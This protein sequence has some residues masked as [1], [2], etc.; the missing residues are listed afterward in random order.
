MHNQRKPFFLGNHCSLP[1]NASVCVYSLFFS[2]H[3]PSDLCSF[4]IPLAPLSCHS[5]TTEWDK[6]P[7]QPHLPPASRSALRVPK[8][9]AH[10]A[11]GTGGGGGGGVPGWM[12][13][14]QQQVRA[15]K[16]QTEF[17]K[18]RLLSLL[19]LPFFFLFFLFKGYHPRSPAQQHE[20]KLP[21]TAASRSTD[22]RRCHQHAAQP[23]AQLALPSQKPR[24][25]AAVP[26][27]A[28]L[29]STLPRVLTQRCI[30]AAA[31]ALRSSSAMPWCWPQANVCK[32]SDSSV[33]ELC[34]QVLPSTSVE[35]KSNMHKLMIC[36]RDGQN[37]RNFVILLKLLKHKGKAIFNSVQ[38]DSANYNDKSIFCIYP[39]NLSPILLSENYTASPS[40]G[41]S[42]RCAPER[43]TPL[44]TCE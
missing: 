2:H 42:T 35:T 36:Y 25:G 10:H 29:C 38:K 6:E 39:L 11:Q 20:A 30:P 40:C 23:L 32:A 5:R 7:K 37:E 44:T 21:H 43:I 24:C 12:S 26:S 28:P 15:S 3:H 22:Q 18:P 9:C 14:E 17:P 13:E 34:G 16:F 33:S 41:Q 4:F 8:P 27:G 19:F 31:R 1:P